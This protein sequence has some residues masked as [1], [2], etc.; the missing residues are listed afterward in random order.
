MVHRGCNASPGV[1][2]AWT[3]FWLLGCKKTGLTLRH[4]TW[5]D[6]LT[7]EVKDKTALLERARSFGI[8]LRTD[9]Q[10]AAGITLDEATSRED[11]QTLF[12]PCW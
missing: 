1:S 11:V 7:V 8:N 12:I 10:G 3:T 5:F 6:T 2:S 4:K 9:I